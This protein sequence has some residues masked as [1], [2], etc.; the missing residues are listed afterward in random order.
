MMR[1]KRA[2]STVSSPIPRALA[3]ATGRRGS[4]PTAATLVRALAAVTGALAVGVVACSKHESP[5]R[6]VPGTH[7]SGSASASSSASLDLSN[8]VDPSSP[9]ASA[10]GMP[11]SSNALVSAASCSASVHV[12]P[13]IPPGP[14]PGTLGSIGDIGNF[15]NMAG[16]LAPVNPDPIKT[17]TPKVV[18]AGLSIKGS[19]PA[20][21][22]RKIVR[23]R[24]GA[25]RACYQKGLAMDPTLHGVVSTTFQIQSDGIVKSASESSSLGSPQV[26]ACIQRVFM[27]LAFPAADGETTVTYPYSFT[28]VGDA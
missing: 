2:P 3:P 19:E 14:P 13:H 23:A 7:A 24:V 26:E 16:G 20:E 6:D 27:T 5:T 4:I 25:I 8:A 18:E 12:F 10:T 17:A 9:L 28:T 22:V 11:S 21:V 15:P 1:K